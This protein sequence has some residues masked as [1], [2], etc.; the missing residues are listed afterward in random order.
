MPESRLEN[1]QQ[2]GSRLSKTEVPVV[3]EDYEYDQFEDEVSAIKSIKK[4]TTQ[5]V[6]G[7]NVEADKEVGG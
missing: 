1:K 2:V 4:G 5:K 6:Q 7:L 3:E